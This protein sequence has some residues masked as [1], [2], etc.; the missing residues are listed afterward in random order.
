MLT[1]NLWTT[2]SDPTCYIYKW[3]LNNQ[4]YNSILYCTSGQRILAILFGLW[5]VMFSRSPLN[6]RVPIFSLVGTFH[7]CHYVQFV[8]SERQNFKLSGVSIGHVQFINLWTNRQHVS[9]LYRH[10]QFITSEW[11]DFEFG[12]LW[13]VLSSSPPLNQWDPKLHSLI[14]CESLLLSY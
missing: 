5:S 7:S 4:V 2:D 10:V 14:L 3:S 9:S 6:W 1:I 8:T 11:Y 13:M 12:S